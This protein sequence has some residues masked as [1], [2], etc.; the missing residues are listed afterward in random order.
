M[1]FYVV[2]FFIAREQL[3]LEFLVL[4][5]PALFLFFLLELFS[6]SAKPFLNVANNVLGMLYLV[7]PMVMLNFMAFYKGEYSYEP[8]LGMLFLI[9]IY[10]SWAYLFGSLLGKTPLMKRISPK[11]T[12]EGLAGGL[13]GCLIVALILPFIFKSF[14]KTDWLIIAGL[15][16]IFGTLGDL[17]ESMFKRDLEIKDSGNLLPG[18][19]GLLDRFDALIFAVPFVWIYIY[20]FV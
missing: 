4:A 12:V 11:K 5:I 20:L 8:M 13:I 19:G 18:H 17:I 16:V 9:W 1:F 3:E 10:D 2:S 14:G 7:A 6:Q 15:I